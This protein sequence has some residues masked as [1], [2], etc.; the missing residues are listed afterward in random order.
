[1]YK[2]GDFKSGIDKLMYNISTRAIIPYYSLVFFQFLFIY[3]FKFKMTDL[4]FSGAEF[5]WSAFIID[6]CWPSSSIKG[7]GLF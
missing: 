1:M 7:W 4:P 6:F 5:I 3:L 2:A